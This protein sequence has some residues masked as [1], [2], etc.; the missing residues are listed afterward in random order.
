MNNFTDCGGNRSRVFLWCEC[1]VPAYH[2]A[3][4]IGRRFHPSGEVAESSCWN[5][6]WRSSQHKDWERRGRRYTIVAFGVG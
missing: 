4:N 5:L 2:R 1:D 3:A 6:S